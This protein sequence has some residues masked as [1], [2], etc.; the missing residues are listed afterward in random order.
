[1]NC[2]QKQDKE[3]L[4]QNTLESMRYHLTRIGYVH[5]AYYL[6]SLILL[7]WWKLVNES[8]EDAICVRIVVLDDRRI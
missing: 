2:L 5:F 8:N 7:N 1:V 6:L 3:D 4:F